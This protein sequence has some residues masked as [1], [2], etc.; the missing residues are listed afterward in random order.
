MSTPFDQL[1]SNHEQQIIKAAIPYLPTNQKKMLSIYVKTRELMSTIQLMSSS[2]ETILSACS[3]DEGDHKDLI[4]AIREV[5]SPKECEF[6][7]NFLQI[8]QVLAIYKELELPKELKDLKEI[9]E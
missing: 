4:H 7:D 1:I 8:Q 5:C 2:D 9:I 3:T 6:L